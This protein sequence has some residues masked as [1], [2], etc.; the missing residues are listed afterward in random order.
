MEND[1]ISIASIPLNLFMK[2][3]NSR[4]LKENIDYVTEQSKTQAYGVILNGEDTDLYVPDLQYGDNDNDTVEAKNWKDMIS[5]LDYNIEDFIDN[6]IL[7]TNPEGET[8]SDDYIC[9]KIPQISSEITDEDINKKYKYVYYTDDSKTLRTFSPF[10]MSYDRNGKTYRRENIK[11]QYNGEIINDFDTLVDAKTIEIDITF[12]GLFIYNTET[13]SG[14]CPHEFINREANTTAKL[15]MILKYDRDGKRYLTTTSESISNISIYEHEKIMQRKQDAAGNFI[16]KDVNG[17]EI[18]LEDYESKLELFAIAM[19]KGFYG[20]H[21]EA[22]PEEKIDPFWM[23]IHQEGDLNDVE[24]N[25]FKVYWY[26]PT[27]RGTIIENI[28]DIDDSKILGG[29]EDNPDKYIIRKIEDGVES[30]YISNSSDIDDSSVKID[31][32]RDN[33][34]NKLFDDLLKNENSKEP[35]NITRSDP[36]I[37]VITDDMFGEIESYD[38]Y[39]EKTPNDE[40]NI[41][42]VY[43]SNRDYYK[44]FRHSH[45]DINFKEIH[46]KKIG[47][48]DVSD[49]DMWFDISTQCIRFDRG[50]DNYT[51]TTTSFFSSNCEDN[52]VTN[53][54]HTLKQKMT[55]S[56]YDKEMCGLKETP[57][58]S[59]KKFI[60]VFYDSVKERHYMVVPVMYHNYGSDLFYRDDTSSSWFNEKDYIYSKALDRCLNRKLYNSELYKDNKYYYDKATFSFDI[61]CKQR[62]APYA[63]RYFNM[64]C[65]MDGG[66]VK[67]SFNNGTNNMTDFKETEDVKFVNGIPDSWCNFEELSEND[68][69]LIGDKLGDKTISLNDGKSVITQTFY[70]YGGISGKNP[71]TQIRKEYDKR[72]VDKVLTLDSVIYSSKEVV[73]GAKPFF[74]PSETPRERSVR[75]HFGYFK[76]YIDLEGIPK[77]ESKLFKEDIPLASRDLISFNKINK[78]ADSSVKNNEFVSDLV[79]NV[80]AANKYNPGTREYNDTTVLSSCL[81]NNSYSQAFITIP[82]LF[83]I[84]PSV[85]YTDRLGLTLYHMFSSEAIQTAIIPLDSYP[86]ISGEY[87]PYKHGS[88]TGYYKTSLDKILKYHNYNIHHRLPLMSDS[89][90]KTIS[91]FTA[92]VIK[93]SQDLDKRFL[94]RDIR[95]VVINNPTSVYNNMCLRECPVSEV[96]NGLYYSS[97]DNDVLSFDRKKLCQLYKNIESGVTTYDISY[98]PYLD[99]IAFDNSPISVDEYQKS[100][101]RSVNLIGTY[102][103]SELNEM[104]TNNGIATLYP[105]TESFFYTT[106]LTYIKYASPHILYR[107]N[108]K[109]NELKSNNKSK[110]KDAL[111]LKMI[112]LANS[113]IFSDLETKEKKTYYAVIHNGKKVISFN[114]KEVN[115]NNMSEYYPGSSTITLWID[116]NSVEIKSICGTCNYNASN[117]E[118]S[119]FTHIYTVPRNNNNGYINISP[120]IFYDM[121]GFKKYIWSASNC[122]TDK[123]SVS[124]G[125]YVG[126][127]YYDKYN[128]SL[129]ASV[130]SLLYHNRGNDFGGILSIDKA[131][132]EENSLICKSSR[133]NA[134]GDMLQNDIINE[135]KYSTFN[136]NDTKIILEKRKYNNIETTDGKVAIDDTAVTPFARVLEYKEYPLNEIKNNIAGRN[137]SIESLTNIDGEKTYVNNE[138]SVF[139][140]N[141]AVNYKT[142]SERFKDFISDAFMGLYNN[143]DKHRPAN[144]KLYDII[145]SENISKFDANKELFLK[146]RMSNNIPERRVFIG[147]VSD[148]AVIKTLINDDNKEYKWVIL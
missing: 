11:I 107:N 86:I 146:S 135:R 94:R 116:E 76:I 24:N 117:P 102:S 73:T 33:I 91:T 61:Y 63:T 43:I 90:F 126:T 62:S 19:R 16:V 100:Y 65:Y 58:F 130:K 129:E 23:G 41:A 28:T 139:D 127:P 72:T 12:T 48:M 123:Y 10:Y 1:K 88:E 119:E 114:F 68:L 148:Y 55:Y 13:Y 21:G 134:L 121:N 147:D 6:S 4:N 87:K 32:I 34:G 53:G 132:S 85:Y 25:K 95:T 118:E 66:K 138:D 124:T 104:L 3:F 71:K 9:F 31:I 5:I 82:D 122:I 75:Y 136:S 133:I 98:I 113:M 79:V 22:K 2:Y 42:D 109:D 131:Y 26:Y 74:N 36:E 97:K 70:N 93:P 105:H 128:S 29:S 80:K 49:L 112:M 110:F 120:D 60:K 64:S 20:L 78:N 96:Q 115:I 81:E 50:I 140:Y 125:N 143:D 106:D 83:K 39:L 59:N 45:I 18:P 38:V 44:M 35:I 103:N 56:T 141:N 89:D 14:L 101:Y 84:W 108:E 67:V 54:N 47:G 57:Y 7:F 52:T 142:R 145:S 30:F 92:S 137:I 27:N 77:G 17:V 111:K 144:F 40:S 99:E 46:L 8:R 37:N 69:S 15:N 51:Y